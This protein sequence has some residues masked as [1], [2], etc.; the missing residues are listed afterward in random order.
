LQRTQGW[1]TLIRGGARVQEF[2]GWAT[3]RRLKDTVDTVQPMKA[4]TEAREIEKYKKLVSEMMLADEY[5]ESEFRPDWIRQRGWKV[6]PVEDG[7][8]FRDW[9]I[10]TIVPALQNAG[11]RDCVAVATE[12]LDPFPSCFQLA[13]TPDDLR[14][15]NRECGLLRFLLTED[16]RSWAISCNE[17]YNLFAGEQSLVEA[18]LGIS[19]EEARKRFLAFAEPLALGNTA[20]PLLKAAQHYAHF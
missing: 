18:M 4:I 10:A 13:I 1:G 8:H 15:F 7:N 2:E 20:Y 3:R 11:Y 12:P 5:E 16:T 9:E 19:V 17:L 14:E 6:V